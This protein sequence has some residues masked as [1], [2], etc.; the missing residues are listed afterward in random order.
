MN[1]LDEKRAFM[2]SHKKTS[3]PFQKG[4]RKKTAKELSYEERLLVQV[5]RQ[6]RPHG[7]GGKN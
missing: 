1:P 3:G 4:G 2:P 7:W 6:I 5:Q